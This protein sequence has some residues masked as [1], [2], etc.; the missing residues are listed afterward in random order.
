MHPVNAT[1]LKYLKVIIAPLSAVIV[2][3]VGWALTSAYN[4]TQFDIAR[5][6]NQADV[7]VAR[8]NAAL[9]FANIYREI[10]DTDVQQK[11]QALAIAAPVLSPELAFDL[12]IKTVN[13]NQN[14]LKIL[15]AKYGDDSWD[16][17]TP[18]LELVPLEYDTTLF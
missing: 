13:R 5:G 18:T 8:I 4:K 14:I 17:V 3:A 16:Y 1:M 9:S 15:L 6:K 11:D 2:A 7:E 12:A 10:P